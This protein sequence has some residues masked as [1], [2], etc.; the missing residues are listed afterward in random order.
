MLL[1][2]LIRNQKESLV[3]VQGKRHVYYKLVNPTIREGWGHMSPEEV[4]SCPTYDQMCTCYVVRIDSLSSCNFL[5]TCSWLGIIFGACRLSWRFPIRMVDIEDHKS[6]HLAVSVPRTASSTWQDI[7]W[8]PCLCC[9]TAHS[10]LLGLYS[11]SHTWKTK[12]E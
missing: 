3:L 1:F 10:C 6:I 5:F 11:A 2:L 9:A 8:F 12:A 4:S 7:L